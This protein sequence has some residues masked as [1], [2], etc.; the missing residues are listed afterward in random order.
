M[1][2]VFDESNAKEV[3]DIIKAGGIIAFPTDT[4]YGF[5]V[6]SDN[7][8]A[9]NRLVSVKNR[10]NDKPFTLMCCS[11]E[12]IKEYAYI[13]NKEEKFLNKFLPGKLTVVLHIKKGHP[14]Q[15]DLGTGFIGIR[16]PQDPFVID[17]ISK[18]E[19]PILVPSANKACEPPCKNSDEIIKIFKDEIDGVVKGE[20]LNNIP[21]TVIKLDNGKIE[22]LRE[23]A[24]P[25]SELKK[26]WEEE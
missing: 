16:I 21:S 19:K 13:N 1:I 10:P 2:K 14:H 26:A 12:Q 24:I 5:G 6:I 3:S 17:F 11:I 4:I 9:F 23:G 7:I 22:L 18:C 25:Y 20:C 15:I 8:D